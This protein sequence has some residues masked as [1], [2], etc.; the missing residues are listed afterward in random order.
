MVFAGGRGGSR[1]KVWKEKQ[2]LVEEGCLRPWQKRKSVMNER[3]IHEKK[4]VL[5]GG[6]ANGG[7][8]VR[9]E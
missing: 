7:G 2:N 4:V 6:V 3:R 1:P 5:W 8:T 9:R